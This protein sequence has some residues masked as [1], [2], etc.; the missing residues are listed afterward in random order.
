MKK[1]NV[2]VLGSGGNA[3]RNFVSSLRLDSTINVVVGCDI[4]ASATK[5]NNCDYN[6]IAPRVPKEKLQFYLDLIKKHSISY[7]HAQPDQ[8]VKFLAENKNSFNING[9]FFNLELCDI[10][11]DKLLCQSIWSEKLGLNYLSSK[12]TQCTEDMFDTIVSKSG[13]AWVRA[14]SG[15]GSRG[16]LPVSTL[17]QAMNWASYWEEE[18]GLPIENFMVSEFLPGKEYAVQTLWWN[19]ELKHLQARERI[20]YVFAR[21][22]PSG[23]SSTP[24]IAQIVNSPIVE[25]RAI[26]TVT[27]IDKKPHGIYCIDL[28]TNSDN[29]I[30]PME[31]NYGRLFTTSLFFSKVGM[32][33]PVDIIKLSCGEDIQPK[34]SSL[35]EVYCYRGLDMQ[36]KVV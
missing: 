7:I 17:K 32:N 35:P 11:S 1:Q 16:A 8:E 9:S 31:I 21:Q 5:Y 34:I 24:S 20:E 23:Q 12:L 22:M 28:K 29:N 26:E 10:F 27:A 25:S 3:A 13:K 33:T 15:A 19:G 2:L 14:I 4:S 30:I 18:K 36:M 6:Y